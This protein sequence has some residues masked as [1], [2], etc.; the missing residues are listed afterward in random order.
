MSP[1]S[2]LPLPFSSFQDDTVAK[3]VP[4]RI[5]SMSIH[6]TEDKVLLA[7]GGKWGAVGIWDVN[8]VDSHSH[9]VS[10]FTV[11]P[12]IDEMPIACVQEAQ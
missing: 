10:L 8:D 9:G 3:V 4:D 5:F 2:L 11:R 7:V 1:V 6:P 12:W